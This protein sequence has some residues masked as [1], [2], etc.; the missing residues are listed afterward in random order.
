VARM[1]RH[2]RALVTLTAGVLLLGACADD[3]PTPGDTAAAEET[4]AADETTAPEDGATGTTEPGDAEATITIQDFSFGDDVTVPVGATV[5]VVNADGVAHTW[6]AD[7]GA[8]DSGS[9]AQDDTFTY[10]ADTAGTYAF[11]C[12]IH[13]AM[14]GTLT[15]GETDAAT[16]ARMGA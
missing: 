5:E 14:T 7:D 10:V 3:E 6:T 11:S 4:T 12:T 16:A 15:V 9:L 8:F 2:T 1:R 13:P